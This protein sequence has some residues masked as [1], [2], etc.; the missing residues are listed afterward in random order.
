MKVFRPS[1]LKAFLNEQGLYAKKGL[2]QNFL[3]DGNIVKKILEIAAIKSGDKVIEIGP[4][5]GALTQA[6][7]ERGARVVAIEKDKQLAQ[8]LERLQTQDERLEVICADFLEIAMDRFCDGP[9][10]VVANLP[11]HITT[12]I[13]TKLLP[14]HSLIESLTIMVQ[15]EFAMRMRAKKKTPEYGSF[16]LFLQFYAAITQSFII[17]RTCFYPAPKVDSCVVRCDL[18][19]PLIEDEKGLFELT[20]TAFGKRRKMLRSSLSVIY[21]V[22]KIE[23]ALIQMGYEKTARPEDLSVEEFISLFVFLKD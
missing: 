11:Y 9:Y 8:A 3:I 4:G 1:D 15:K 10:K 6:L 20:R 2:S 5:P 19:P 16:T 12:P 13:L 17:K 21:P 22:E 23:N 7:L 14:M 18:H